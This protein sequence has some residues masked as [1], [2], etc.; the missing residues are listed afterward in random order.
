[1]SQGR[2]I[3]KKP[4]NFVIRKVMSSEKQNL[5]LIITVFLLNGMVKP[6]GCTL[7]MWSS[8]WD[9]LYICGQAIETDSIYVVKPLYVVKSRRY[10]LLSLVIDS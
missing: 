6:L 4:R 9:G 1:M 5:R 8:H 2:N 7:Y 3:S 10:P